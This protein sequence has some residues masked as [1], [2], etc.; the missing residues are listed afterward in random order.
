MKE[1]DHTRMICKC[2]VVAL[3]LIW[4]AGISIAA[5]A[6]ERQET[7]D[8][9]TEYL[10]NSDDILRF[11]SVVNEVLDNTFSSSSFAV[12]QKTKGVYLQGYGINFTFVIN[13]YR[14]MLN[15][16]FGQ[17]R[18]TKPPVT[19]EMKIQRIEELKAKLIQVLQNNCEIFQHLRKE[20]NV[21]IVAFF[22]DRNFPGEP[23]ANKTIVLSV[24]KKDL[25]ELGHRNDRLKEFKQRMKIVEY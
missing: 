14:A 24:L 3:L 10:S 15:T 7:P 19:P 18:S 16:P 25:D 17:I 8:A 2:S 1:R 22:E 23:S 11:E 5:R 9:K 20:D 4:T 13:I 6:L 12:V 21:S